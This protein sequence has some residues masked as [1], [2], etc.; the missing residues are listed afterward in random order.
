MASGA[1]EGG[2]VLL[3]LVPDRLGLRLP[4]AALHIPHHTFPNV[5]V[6]TLESFG[7]IPLFINA[8]LN[9]AAS[10]AASVCVVSRRTKSAPVSPDVAGS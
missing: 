1:G 5:L 7:M 6:V 9:L 10:P 4:I 3:Q 2:K 8:A